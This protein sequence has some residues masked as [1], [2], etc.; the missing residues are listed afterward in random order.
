M[1]TA[2]TLRTGKATFT[3]NPG[4]EFKYSIVTVC[5]E[6]FGPNDDDVWVWFWHSDFGKKMEVPA[7]VEIIWDK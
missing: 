4:S 6:K 1:T 3:N 5:E 7:G 2:T